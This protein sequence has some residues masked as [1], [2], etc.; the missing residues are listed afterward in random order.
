MI[1]IINY[2]SGNIQAIRN[3][4][5]RLG[6]ENKI[7]SNISEFD[8]T[9]K[10]ILPGVGSFDETMSQLILSGIKD[11]LDEEVFIKKTPVL[12]ICVGMQLLSEGSDE[13]QM[14]GLGWIKGRV[15]KFEKHNIPQKPYVP[16]MGWNSVTPK[17]EHKLFEGIDQEF[18]FY[19]VHSYYFKTI[20][21]ENILATSFYGSEFASAVFSDNIFGVQF[22]PEKSHSNGIRVLKNFAEY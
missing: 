19:F 13:G 1:G 14:N 20:Q 9:D 10:L 8:S 16:H 6:V 18:G 3:I 2:G 7:I 17:F 11:K 15:K 4:Y 5:N 21:A 12:G 22:H